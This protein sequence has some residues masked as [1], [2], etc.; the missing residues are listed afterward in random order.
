MLYGFFHECLFNKSMSEIDFLTFSPLVFYYF[1]PP[2]T[3]SLISFS[4]CVQLQV[5]RASFDI[6]L[7]VNMPSEFRFS[8]FS[9]FFLFFCFLLNALISFAVGY[10]HPH[11]T[12]PKAIPSFFSPSIPLYYFY[13][14][15]WTRI[16]FYGLAFY[17]LSRLSSLTLS[18][19]TFLP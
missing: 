12:D 18:I 7:S 9:F 14:Y 8:F 19:S 15:S 13:Y 2:P 5:N 3:L 16:L 10:P 4:L 1:A 17:A 11:T 6:I